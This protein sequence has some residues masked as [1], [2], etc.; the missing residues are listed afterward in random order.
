MTPRVILPEVTNIN[1][2]NERD[3]AKIYEESCEEDVIS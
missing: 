2:D 3:F 1:I